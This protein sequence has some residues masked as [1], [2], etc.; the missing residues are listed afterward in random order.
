MKS[1]WWERAS[2]P[3]GPTLQ[4]EARTDV[5]V[6][7]GGI[8][9]LLCAYL[10]TQAGANCLLVEANTLC[11]GVTG[12]TTA[13]ITAQ[14][15]LCY[16]RF[17]R[18]FGLERTR[19]LLSAQLE[20]VEQ[21]RDLCWKL[22]CPFEAKDS[23]VY[24]LQ[25][26]E[27][28]ALE[29][30]A[31]DRLGYPAALA[32]E[33]PLPVPVAGAVRFPNQGQFH[34]LEFL[35]AVAKDLTFYEHTPVLRLE[36]TTA[37][38]PQG[39]IRAEQV[40]VATHFPFLNRHGGYFLKLYQHRSYVLAL[41]HA[42][43][44]NGMYVDDS[45][46]GLSF[47]N[48]EGLLL[49]GGGSH[50]TGGQGGNWDTLSAFALRHY[51]QARAVCRWATQDCMSLD[52]VPYIGRYSRNLPGVFVASG[53]NKW[54]MTSSMV[55]AAVL[56]DLALGRENPFADAFR[57]DRTMPLLPLAGNALAAGANLLTPLPRRCPHMGCAL[58]WN[59][60]EHSWDCPCHG[61]RFTQEGELLSNPA[62]RG[63]RRED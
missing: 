23:F 36:G 34:P 54:G 5:L 55:A 15:G 9:G 37:I 33:L 53:F 7:G 51:P 31:L 16:H 6:I 39:R 29:L 8:S 38:T 25:D 27:A 56:R 41:E 30:E 45:G 11:S 28:I 19:T 62:M 60:A 12:N 44:V 3:N 40:I 20:A 48:A 46:K 26:R 32:E 2:L 1:I 35:S 18:R 42:P 58:R 22:G 59:E 43:D 17:L 61:S 10:L 57:P 47:R 21:Y 63:L 50:R 52:Q 14:H 13:K 49:L 24:T 4:S